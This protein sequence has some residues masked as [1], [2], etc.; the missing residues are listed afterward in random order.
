MTI[1]NGREATC[2]ALTPNA[3]GSFDTQQNVTNNQR[4][5]FYANE[6]C[7][8]RTLGNVNLRLNPDVTKI[9][10][11]INNTRANASITAAYENAPKKTIRFFAPWTNTSAILY[12]ASPARTRRSSWKASAA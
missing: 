5:N 10:I 11:T 4:I 7:T 3:D 8:G 9:N 1:G 12:T 2:I 6:R